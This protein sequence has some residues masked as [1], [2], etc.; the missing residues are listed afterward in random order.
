MKT[1][2]DSLVTLVAAATAA[3]AEAA[4]ASPGPEAAYVVMGQGGAVARVIT[5][6][7]RCPA[8]V[9]DGRA[10]MMTVRAAAATLPQRPTASPPALSK[11]SDFPV[12]VCDAPV[13]AGARALSVA[14]KRLPV[15]KHR[16]RRIVVIGDTGCRLKAADGAWQACN[17]PA[18]FAFGRIA[19]SAAGWKPDLVI[20]VGDYLYRENPCPTGNSG[21]AAS[22]WGYGWDAWTADFFTPAA[23]LLAAAP[24]APA[25]GNHES[26][27]RAG[28][29]WWRL[30]DPRPLQPGRDC[31]DPANDRTGDTSPPY[32]VDLGDGGRVIMMDM[33]AVGGK[34]LAADDWRVPALRQTYAQV[35][36]LARGARFAF[37]VDHYPILGFAAEKGDGGS[38]LKPGNAAIQSVFGSFGPRMAPAGIDALLAGHVHLWQQVGFAGDQPSQFITGFSGT[39]E[40]EV[41]MPATI[42]NGVAPAPGARVTA[43]SSWVSGFGYMTMARAGP[44]SWRVQVHD[45]DGR[46]V[47]RCTIT[48]QRSQ[49]RVGSVDAALRTATAASG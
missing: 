29:G 9:A 36:D 18:A 38:H 16:I 48:G 5:S 6:A 24:I 31:D 17:D 41:P 23:P 30:L 37:A 42:P 33:A 4:A 15:P 10:I 8:L 45:R 11:P 14:G 47:N 43:F 22:P 2:V 25:R 21:C 46:I 40:D 19:A 34:A 27:A 7:T 26:C 39:Q 12:T 20:H 28:Q 44:R 32:A 35:G 3:A 49:C 13:P 1:V